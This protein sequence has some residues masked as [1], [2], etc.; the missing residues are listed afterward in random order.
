MIRSLHLALTAGLALAVAAAALAGGV[1]PPA[2]RAPMAGP[3]VARTG[4][5]LDYVFFASDRPVLISTTLTGWPSLMNAT[6]F[7]CSA[8]RISFTPM[9]PRMAAR[10]K[11]GRS[12]GRAG[13]R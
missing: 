6:L 8:C 1:K 2:A 13:R 12:A 11:T 9:N 10:P 5:Q 7:S 4:D 3:R